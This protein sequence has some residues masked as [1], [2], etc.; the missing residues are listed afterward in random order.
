MSVKQTEILCQSQI[1]FYAKDAVN[2]FIWVPVN[3]NTHQ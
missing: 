3:Q 1:Q 2:D